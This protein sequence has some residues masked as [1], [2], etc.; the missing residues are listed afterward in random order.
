MAGTQDGAAPAI[1]GDR[2]A[3]FKLSID[4]DVGGSEW[5]EFPD[6]V[7]VLIEKSFYDRET[8]WRFHGRIQSDEVVTQLRKLGTTGHTI[9]H[10]REKFPNSPDFADTIAGFRR[11]FDPSKAY[12]SEHD[13][14]PAPSP[15]AR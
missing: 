11:N 2:V 6:G 15:S 12:F 3:V 14:S 8:G 7:E 10:Y 9:E 1:E 13:L 4:N 5:Q